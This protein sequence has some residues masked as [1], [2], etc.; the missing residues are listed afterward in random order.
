MQSLSAKT[1]QFHIINF[2]RHLRMERY[3]SRFTLM[4]YQLDL[5]QLLKFVEEQYFHEITRKSLRSFLASLSKRGLKASSINR[6]LT[7]LRSFFKYLCSREILDANPA[8]TLL[9][10]KKEKKL[11][12][13][14]Q[15]EVILK[16]LSFPDTN[17]IEGLRD[18]VI[19]E[20]FYST[21]IRL[22]ELVGINL[23]DVDLT[24][25]LLKVTGKGSKERLVPLGK[26]IIRIIKEYIE[27]R[28]QYIHS[29]DLMTEAFFLNKKG[30][31]ISPGQVQYRVKKYLLLASDKQEA[32]PHMLRHSFAT[33]LLDEGADLIAVKELLGH[34]S[35]STT[36]V[37][38]H[39]TTERLKKV[40]KQAH[41]RAQK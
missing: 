20:I 5:G 38:T 13:F 39:L 22:R 36:Q 35:L 1:L 9:Y 28:A 3:V 32:Y 6:K 4:A 21:G 16:A 17:N 7:S 30:E 19:L 11:P 18:R 40:Y 10:L 34:S 33:H 8:A 15:Y 37:Y 26:S 23:E 2:L 29:L 27:A 41:P 25:E 31:R 24:H 14:F 12:S